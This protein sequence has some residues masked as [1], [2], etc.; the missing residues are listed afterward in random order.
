MLGHA[1]RRT[2]GRADTI[3]APPTADGEATPRDTAP[4]LSAPRTACTLVHPPRRNHSTPQPILIRRGA[5]GD[6]GEAGMTHE[7]QRA[8]TREAGEKERIIK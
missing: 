2:R 7:R 1:F 3:C 6:A 8:A 4:G 5:A